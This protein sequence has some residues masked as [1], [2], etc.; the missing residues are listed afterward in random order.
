[1]DHANRVAQGRSL[2]EIAEIDPGHLKWAASPAMK[3][4]NIRKAC[5]QFLDQ[6]E[7]ETPS[8]GAARQ[9]ADDSVVAADEVPFDLGR[10]RYEAIPGP[11]R[12]NTP[13]EAK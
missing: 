12:Q 9:P 4:P 2:R 10:R 3:K 5:R 13:E 7:A 1:M 11:P 8:D 6:L